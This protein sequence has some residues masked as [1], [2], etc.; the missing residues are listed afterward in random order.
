MGSKEMKEY[1]ESMGIEV[2]GAGEAPTAQRPAPKTDKPQQSNTQAYSS[3]ADRANSA[4]AGKSQ[5]P[6]PG[7]GLET[8]LRAPSQR[9]SAAAGSDIGRRMQKM[10]ALIKALQAQS[11]QTAE[12][13]ESP[14]Q[15]YAPQK[16]TIQHKQINAEPKML[17]E[18]VYI[19]SEQTKQ[20]GFARN[21]AGKLA[22]GISTG[23]KYTVGLP[24]I[25]PLS[26]Y[27]ALRKKKAHGYKSYP[28]SYAAGKPQKKKAGLLR[29]AVGIATL[30]SI[31]G[32]CGM[33]YQ[34]QRTYDNILATAAQN[35][36]LDRANIEINLGSETKF[37]YAKDRE[38]ADPRPIGT[39]AQKESHRY[40]MK[41]EEIRTACQSCEEIIIN[42]E[43][44]DFRTNKGVKW[45]NTAGG[46]AESVLSKIPYLKKLGFRER[47][48]STLTQQLAK[49]IFGRK[50]PDKELPELK[51]PLDYA[52]KSVPSDR[53]KAKLSEL[54]LSLQMT[55]RYSKGQ[56]MEWFLTEGLNYGKN[57]GLL[58]AAKYFF[59]VD[60]SKGGMLDELQA[61]FIMG[62]IK[63]P[64]N[65]TPFL[66]AKD[67]EKIVGNI[68]NAEA[69]T[70]ASGLFRLYTAGK[71]PYNKQLVFADEG[72]A[73]AEEARINEMFKNNM[74]IKFGSESYKIQETPL[75]RREGTSVK[76]QNQAASYLYG[77]DKFKKMMS[78]E[79]KKARQGV[80]ALSEDE[81][82]LLFWNCGGEEY[83]SNTLTSHAK[84]ELDELLKNDEKLRK[85]LQER[86]IN[87]DSIDSIANAGLSIGLTVKERDYKNAGYAMKH[88]SSEVGWKLNGYHK[89]QDDTGAAA[90]DLE[91]LEEGS[92]Y[93]AHIAAKGINTDKKK[94]G[95]K[96]E[97]FIEAEIGGLDGKTGIRGK[98]DLA[99]VKRLQEN[100][101]F[102]S[103]ISTERIMNEFREGNLV[104]V[105][106]REKKPA[107]NGKYGYVFDIE[108]QHYAREKG[109]I[110][111]DRNRR[112]IPLFNGG[113]I[114]VGS[115]GR[116]IFKT[117][118]VEDSGNP[119]DYTMFG[120]GNNGYLGGSTSKPVMWNILLGY[121]LNPAQPK[122][123]ADY[124]QMISS[125][126]IPLPI[127]TSMD[128]VPGESHVPLAAQVTPYNAVK[129]SINNGNKN[130]LDEFISI[131]EILNGRQ[132][133]L[134]V[135]RST[136]L[137]RRNDEDAKGYHKRLRDTKGVGIDVTFH[138]KNWGYI[139]FDRAQRALLRNADAGLERLNDQPEIK[140]YL[141]EQIRQIADMGYGNPQQVLTE[142]SQ[143]AA[144]DAAIKDAES[145]LERAESRKK[146]IPQMMVSSLYGTFTQL[147]KSRAEVDG[148][149][150]KAAAGDIGALSKFFYDSGKDAVI[151]SIRK[152]FIGDPVFEKYAKPDAG[153][154]KRITE[155][156]K[157]RK[158]LL[159]RGISLEIFGALK[160]AYDI[161][162][163][164]LNAAANDLE[165][166]YSEESLLEHPVFRSLAGRMYVAEELKKKGFKNKMDPTPSMI[167]GTANVTVSE[168][169][170]A[171][172]RDMTGYKCEPYIIERIGINGDALFERER[173]RDVSCK[174]ADG[175]NEELRQKYAALLRGAATQGG[176]VS[177][178][179]GQTGRMGGRSG[180]AE[181]EKGNFINTANP[182]LSMEIR[183]KDA[184]G[185]EQ[186]T[187][188]VIPFFGKT[189]T[190]NNSISNLLSGAVPIFSDDI[191]KGSAAYFTP[192]DLMHISAVFMDYKGHPLGHMGQHITGGNSAGKSLESSVLKY[193]AA[194]N[195]QEKIDPSILKPGETVTL[196][197]KV[198]EGF[199]VAYIDSAGY[200]VTEDKCL[201]RNR[202]P[203][204]ASITNGFGPDDCILITED[205]RKGRFYERA[206]PFYMPLISVSSS[207]L[208]IAAAQTSASGTAVNAATPSAIN[209]AR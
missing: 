159:E 38:D 56:I 47:G 80:N 88:A 90:K 123:N 141:L 145:K 70:L 20:K 156:S 36:K 53:Y 2:G 120:P 115:G 68:N 12:E 85:A 74:E 200:Y 143:M 26:A 184:D 124:R 102:Y 65:Y 171:F 178:L 202:R 31:L 103:P 51:F 133:A 14:D 142:E 201:N 122:D 165:Q 55:E 29:Q 151:F 167:L 131:I 195:M 101:R 9:A 206:V 127:S 13:P 92:F 4:A 33:A 121:G 196:E 192:D 116:I 132:A 61:A 100:L 182:S 191:P 146:K 104:Y 193:I 139:A 130:M 10:D 172:A 30:A 28:E 78:V 76:F 183:Y 209:T 95:E 40:H 45:E 198:P 190:T 161:K 98:I 97:P 57:K 125:R 93:T 177:F 96:A 134:D 144:I 17:L 189:G 94:A 54:V 50:K 118:N 77:R 169:A 52:Y 160:Q 7:K 207:D 48:G 37:F 44:A 63:G 69:R 208:D 84:T 41:I 107:E 203:D 42:S 22:H 129:E 149:L 32:G 58:G 199:G 164:E 119:V 158:V 82:K 24:V 67:P 60:M 75:I 135:I 185:Q 66:T 170:S 152:D 181:K 49:N 39:L 112:N 176:T 140:S 128:Y 15:S 3:S 19:K 89:P 5:Q 188:V 117:G 16:E 6:V 138:Q 186:K 87:P 79:R 23:L 18:N 173:N 105:S 148:E 113:L 64:A 204:N 150:T 162:F 71:Y 25:I 147:Q 72:Q 136:P 153:M 73:K 168:I 175:F 27:R 174:R 194:H 83:E 187:R 35:K 43:D 111:K 180:I 163:G 154:I 108:E 155:S 8:R 62:Q 197:Q 109:K 34:A 46:A 137:A 86:G 157:I 114:A 106:V 99:A 179:N 126:S 205:P 91:Q 1:L 81:K 11:G 166:L 21:A 110:S 59:N